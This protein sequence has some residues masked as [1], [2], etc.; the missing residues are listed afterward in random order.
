VKESVAL[1]ASFFANP[2]DPEELLARVGLTEKSGARFRHL[3][4][5]EKQRLSL[6]LA[7][8]GRPRVLFLDEPTSGMDPRARLLTWEIVREARSAGTTVVLTTHS[9][10]EAE[11]LADRVAI[12]NHGALVALDTPARLRGQT[13]SGRLR[14]ELEAT[15]PAALLEEIRGLA[16]V[17]NVTDLGAGAYDLQSSSPRDAAAAVTQLLRDQGPRLLLLR[18]GRTSLEEVFLELTDGDS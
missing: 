9:M 4:G 7:L 6:A 10:E 12:L 5:G 14:L 18:V 13:D 11:R 2:A 1:F 15:L 8:V 16:V 3:S 17:D